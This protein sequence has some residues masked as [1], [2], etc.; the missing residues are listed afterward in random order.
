MPVFR[1]LAFAAM[2]AATSPWLQAATNLVVNGDFEAGNTAFIT[3]YAYSPGGNGA[4]G[5]YTVRADPY[6]W[7]GNFI[8]AAD[9][10]SGHGQMYVGNGSPVDGA[11]VWQSGAITVDAATDYFFEA[12]VMNVCC[13]PGYGGANSPSILEFSINGVAVGTKTTNLALA[14]TWEGLSTTWNSGG[15]T[16]AVLKL[17]NRNTAPGG[18]D[19]AIDDIALSTAT[20]IPEPMTLSLLLLGLP[21]LGLVARRRRAA[22]PAAA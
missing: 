21:G 22:S 16:T 5:Q 19:F 9:H 2:L 6:P 4:E 12:W 15:A 8:S 14:G 11:I 17:I 18:N 1:P 10:S 3:D 13:L 20:T 7:N